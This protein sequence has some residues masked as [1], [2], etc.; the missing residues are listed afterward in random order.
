MTAKNQPEDSAGLPR[1]VLRCS[2]CNKSQ[3]D[4]R[5]LIAGPSV[6]ICDECVQVCNDVIADAARH[7]ER[8]SR[9]GHLDAIVAVKEGAEPHQFPRVPVYA[10][11]VRCA[12]CRMPAPIEDGMLIPN[13]GVLCL[14][15]VGEIE[16]TVAESRQPRS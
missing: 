13:R 10:P 1:P 3:D 16:A 9:A 7:S 14:G 2:F 4:V 11:A 12:L 5:E 8:V 6:F 15:C